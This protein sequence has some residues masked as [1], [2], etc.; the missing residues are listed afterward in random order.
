[1]ERSHRAIVSNGSAIFQAGDHIVLLVE[2][3][4]SNYLSCLVPVIVNAVL[5]EHQICID[6]VI[7]CARGDFPRSRLREKQ[8]G[9]ILSAYITK[10][11]KY[12]KVYD[13][14]EMDGSLDIAL[15]GSM[16]T[17]VLEST[18]TPGTAV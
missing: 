11:L 9:R 18:S 12:C 7:F 15:S 16:L 2:V 17:P 10:K 13:I 14:R 5:N 1:M 3:L 8:R 4:R 6:R